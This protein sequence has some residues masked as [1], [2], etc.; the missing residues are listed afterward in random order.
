MNTGERSR[1]PQVIYKGK[2]RSLIRLMLIPKEG[3]YG[4]QAKI[5]RNSGILVE[6]DLA[7]KIFYR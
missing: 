6:L 2:I 5:K 7:K 1:V 3:T 4:D